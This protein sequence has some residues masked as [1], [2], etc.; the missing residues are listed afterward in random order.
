V[1]GSP[2]SKPSPSRRFLESFDSATFDTLRVGP[3][4]RHATPHRRADFSNL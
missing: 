4:R 1:T 2:P 3:D